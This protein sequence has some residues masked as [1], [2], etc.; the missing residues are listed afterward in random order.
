ME[1]TLLQGS[2]PTVTAP[3]VLRKP[4]IGELQRI[5]RTYGFDLSPEEL[6]AFRDL[7]EGT[8]ASYRRLDQFVEPTLPVKY[9]RDAG[10]RPTA[11]ENRLNAWYWKCS[12]KVGPSGKLA[13]KKI[14]IKDNVCVAGIPMMNG[15]NVLEG[16]VP[17]VDA[18][19]VT[20]IL[21][22]GGEIVGKAVCEHLCFS[23]GS[24]TSDTG[25]VL[26]PHD[27]KRSAG[28]SSSGSAALVVAAECD[29]SMGGDQGGSIRI[30]S[31]YCGAF[32]LKPT[33]GL[34]PY[35]GVFPIELTLDHTGPMARS[36]ADCALL[37]EVIAGPDG[38][39]PRQSAGVRTEAYTQVLTGGARGLRIGIVREGFGWPASEPDVDTL[40]RDAAQR[41]TRAGATVSEISIPLHQDGIHIWNGICIEGATM[42]MVS[43]NSMGTNWKGHYMTPLLDFYAR[44]RRARA[45]DLSETVKLVI[46]LGQYMQDNYH[47]RYYAKAQNLGRVLRAAY[48]E[49]LKGMDLLVMPTTPMKAT[50]IPPPNASREEYVARAL[51]MIPN[52]CPFDVTGHPAMNVPCGMSGGLPV[53]MML[54]GRHWEDGSVLRAA[55]AFEQLK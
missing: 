4:P 27:P 40:V 3:R 54:V 18:T 52:T 32:G 2:P 48:D 37:L 7:M 39:D 5:A 21:D 9:P 46:L 23:G 41:L 42:L 38:L 24:H 43:G 16:F 12:I 28:G 6:A 51:E 1:K 33:Y 8:L 19:I 20:R 13:G 49:A 53:G 44:S 22:A 34:V 11:E 14:A 25:P 31:S 30:P 55:H 17:D 50:L 35:T 29:M 15:S 47:G 45:N 26:N 10:Y 36:A